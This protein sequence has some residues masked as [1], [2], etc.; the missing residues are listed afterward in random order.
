MGRVLRFDRAQCLPR[1]LVELQPSLPKAPSANPAASAFLYAFLG[2]SAPAK[3]SDVTGAKME[4]K[5]AANVA[6]KK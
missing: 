1:Y 3:V 5:K 2:R 4:E 6:A